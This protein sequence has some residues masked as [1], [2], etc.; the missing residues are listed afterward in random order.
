MESSLRS[1]LS[2]ADLPLHAA[3]ILTMVA[4]LGAVMLCAVSAHA[5]ASEPAITS[6]LWGA[7]GEKW[8]P[9]GRLPD[10]SFA[11]YRRG[12]APIPQVPV[13][14]NVRDFGA[15]GDG[16]HDDTTA[17]L[18]AI[19][20][21][22]RGAILLPAGRYRI[23]DIVEIRKPNIVLRGEGPEQTILF[24]PVPLN[25]IRPNMGATTGGRPTSNYSWSG[26]FIWLRGDF[27]SQELSDITES[28]QRGAYEVVVSSPDRLRIGQSI[29]IRQQ[30]EPENTLAE[31]L[32][33]GQP[34]NMNELRGRTRARLTTR[35]TAIDG[36]RITFD[37]P[38]PFDIESRWQPKVLQFE[39]TVTEV[40][41][42][43]LA[44]EFP[45]QKYE[46][47]FTELGF[48]A[49]AF[50]GA[51]DCWVRNIAINHSDSGIFA[52]GRFCTFQ[53]IVYNSD[54][55][56]DRVPDGNT[57]HHGVTLSGD[58]NLY[59]RFRFNNRFIHDITLTAGG[60]G[61]V[62]SEGSGVDL[63]FDHHKRAP[64][65]NLITNVDL[66]EGTRPYRSG[67]GAD[68]GRHSAAWLTFWNIRSARPI[69]WPPEAYAPDMIN[70]VGV[71]SDQEPIRDPQG[72]WFEPVP[73]QHL[74]PQNL[75]HAQLQRRLGEAAAATE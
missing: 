26:G 4:A 74:Q 18:R 71:P 15:R 48:N 56:P 53:D 73:P 29:E 39:P 20:Q 34:G 14:A 31:H 27:R 19:E 44:F 17:I 66:G 49:I 61:N 36:N 9:D 13:A 28:A 55:E 50:A 35:L 23:T 43:D 46:G 8:S 22:E 33:A 58:D 72:R 32:Y 10:Y 38:L 51:V 57:G 3:S 67:G 12:E 75:H 37:R 42:E 7:E 68:L 24:F 25:D 40:G 69:A 54:R 11:G 41:V 64:Y 30:D 62:V 5:V 60:S 1:L 47:H 21:T 63:C 59:T 6:E 70:I 16:E 65:A 45:V 52:S 2:L